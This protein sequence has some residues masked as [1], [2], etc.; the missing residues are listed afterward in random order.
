MFDHSFPRSRVSHR[1]TFEKTVLNSS[2]FR[3]WCKSNKR[4]LDTVV[5]S[6]H[7][8]TS[9]KDSQKSSTKCRIHFTNLIFLLFLTTRYS[10]TVSALL[11]DHF[12]CVAR[13]QIFC[14]RLWFRHA[15]GFSLEVHFLDRGFKWPDSN[16]TIGIILDSYLQP[17]LQMVIYW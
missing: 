5:F 6:R 15:I 12:E 2:F 8:T 13:K 16:V 11:E 10:S 14:I 1:T 3:F 4:H 17:S 9:T 7:T